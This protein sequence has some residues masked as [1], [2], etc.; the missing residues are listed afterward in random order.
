M[1][2]R[3]FLVPVLPLS[4]LQTTKKRE[5]FVNLI[6]GYVLKGLV[7][8]MGLIIAFSAQLHNRESRAAWMLLFPSDQVAG[9]GKPGSSRS[10]NEFCITIVPTSSPPGGTGAA[11]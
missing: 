6:N 7:H 3:A 2:K 8:M 11:K 9:T 1:L 5:G 4:F 10:G